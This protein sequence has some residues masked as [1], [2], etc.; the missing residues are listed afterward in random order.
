MVIERNKAEDIGKYYDLLNHAEETE[1]RIFDP[2]KSF[3][4]KNRA[5]FISNVVNLSDSGKDVYAGLNERKG[6]GK[7][8]EEVKYFSSIFIDFDVHGEA[9]TDAEVQQNVFALN[10]KLKENNIKTSL[11]FSGR[12]Y[13]IIIPFKRI[14]ITNANR[15][16][17]KKKINSF[18]NFLV[19]KFGVDSKTFNLSRVTR[20]IGTLNNSAEKLSY[21]M[22]YD[23]YNDN[24]E[25]ID[26]LNALY[27]QSLKEDSTNT[28]YVEGVKTNDN[29]EEG[30]KCKFFD[31]VGLQE[32]F[33]EGDRHT[34]LM[35]NLGVYTNFTGKF[36]LRKKFCTKQEMS[37]F[38][39]HGWD[40][41]FKT[42]EMKTFNCGEIMNYCKQYN[43]KDV[44]SLCPYNNF[45][46]NE[47][48][49]KN[50]KK[51]VKAG[52]EI[53]KLAYQ[54]A[55]VVNGLHNT[56]MKEYM[57]NLFEVKFLAGNFSNYIFAINSSDFKEGDNQGYLI[58]L[59]NKKDLYEKFKHNPPIENF[60]EKIMLTQG[61]K[62]PT[63]DKL[64]KK[65]TEDGKSL[66]D[67]LIEIDLK[68][69]NCLFYTKGHGID[70]SDMRSLSN[71]DMK[72]IVDEFINM[73]LNID[74][75]VTLAFESDFFI[76]DL[77][78]TDM[79][80]YQYYNPHKFL[81]TGTKA[82]K[83]TI[84][85][86][87]GHNAIRTTVKNLL[88]FATSDEINRGTLHEN[89][90]PY[91]LDEIQEDESKSMYGKL[92]SFME[93]GHVNIDVGKKSI[94]CKGLSSL[95]FLGNPKDDLINKDVD[96]DIKIV[97]Q[98]DSTLKMITNNYSALGSRIAL[99]IFDPNTI[100]LSG[101]NEYTEDEIEDLDAR[102]NYLRYV[103][104][105][106]FS[107]LLKNPKVQEFLNTPFEKNYLT[108]LEGLAKNTDMKSFQEFLLG[109]VSSYRHTNGMAI[110]LAALEYLNDL[111]NFDV[112]IKALLSTAKKQLH[113]IQSMNIDSFKEMI[114]GDATHSIISKYIKTMFD[115]E[116]SEVK[117]FLYA[118][119]SYIREG[120][121]PTNI[122]Y[123]SLYK[124]MK[125]DNEYKKDN[126]STGDITYQVV[127][128]T[129][130]IKQSYMIDV[131]EFDNKKFVTINNDK[132]LKIL[133]GEF[134]EINIYTGQNKLEVDDDG[135]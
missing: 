50:S 121:S 7:S 106:P 37:E 135:R 59:K 91:Y 31:E 104:S 99:T 80:K 96:N 86:R 134:A 67:H 10:G 6:G 35:K 40:E 133:F 15:E 46:Y 20:I 131:F 100:R 94:T 2:A 29:I 72:D 69:T 11:A 126:R 110:R 54:H 13:H 62:S 60:L 22:D 132:I 108:T 76:P 64:K 36:D 48:T 14:E 25:F 90:L 71:D 44:C 83:S 125:N 51:T 43:I 87:M 12:G 92:L 3:F 120:G 4:V 73:N 34:T 122:P 102:F 1:I 42:G 45:R 129:N 81:F 78:V 75:K 18:K 70:E 116:R 63:I 27:E 98:F 21:W 30:R 114:E 82:G 88:G 77:A 61:Y 41:K 118:A 53:K 23:G 103:S 84:S 115:E 66:F 49:N 57:Y 128:F 52:F 117:C 9:I 39:L 101:S 93:N 109:N 95:T 105:K 89:T 33:P 16:D 124:Y 107:L 24:N 65:L 8:D 74:Q 130:K 28:V 55:I 111:I 19:E 97:G 112:D 113:I 5:D 127:K 123:I 119:Y 79:K 17:I 47:K 38:E 85:S 26:F 68:T 32:K 58:P 56:T